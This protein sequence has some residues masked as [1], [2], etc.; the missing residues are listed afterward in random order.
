MRKLKLAFAMLMCF[1]L[2]VLASSCSPEEYGPCSIPKTTALKLAC[3]DGP[4]PT[5][6]SDYVFDCDSLL[7]GV[8]EGSDPFCTHRCVPQNCPEG[9]HCSCP[10]GKNCKT[11]CPEDAACVEWVRES[12]GYFCLPK[13]YN[14][15]QS[16]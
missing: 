5:C 1:S 11:S 9:K 4:S 12:T 6:T 7:C 15:R 2:L 3:F 16:E 8:Y 13:Q 14:N 10:E